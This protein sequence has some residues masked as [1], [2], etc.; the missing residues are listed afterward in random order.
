[1][2]KLGLKKGLVKLVSHDKRWPDFFVKEKN[3]LEKLLKQYIV[4]IEHAGSTSIAGIKA[5]PIID[6]WIGGRKIKDF[7][8][9]SFILES[10]GYFRIP[11]SNFPKYHFVFA[12]GN[13]TAGTTH[14]I[15]LVKYKGSIWKK[16]LKFRD[17]LNNSQKLAKEYENLKIFLKNKYPKDRMAYIKGKDGFVKKV[18]NN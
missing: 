3:I 1:M 2:A 13:A 14:Y 15:H 16:V 12:K 10:N 4:S 5:K 18:L 6:I 8:N 17:R 9:I 7:K 11:N